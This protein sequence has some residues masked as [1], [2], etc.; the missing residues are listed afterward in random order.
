MYARSRKTLKRIFLGLVVVALITGVFAITTDNT[1]ALDESTV[2]VKLS[3]GTPDTFNFV[4]QGNYGVDQDPSLNLSTG[5]YRVWVDAGVLKLFAGS[6]LLYAGSEIYV[7]EKAPFENTYNYASIKT[8]RYGTNKYLGDIEFRYDRGHI[9]VINHVYLDYYVYGV[10]PHEMSNT[11]PLE[12]LKTQAVAART[13]AVRYMGG[14]SYDL[15]DT[16]ANQVYRGFDETKTNAIQA[17][18]ETAKMVL[19][20]GGALVPT[21]YSASKIG[22]AHV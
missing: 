18:D 15:V 5:S 6:Q 2:R 11:W 7:Q 8:T 21:F 22:R 19:M 17:V 12:A 9:D 3:V 14:G 16:S 13:Y 1:Q 4:L 10:V 20:S